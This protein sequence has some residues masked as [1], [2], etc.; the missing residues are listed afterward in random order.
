MSSFGQHR[1]ARV[2]Q[3]CVRAAERVQDVGQG[4]EGEAKPSRSP[5]L[6]VVLASAVRGATSSFK[7]LDVDGKR[8]S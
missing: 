8:N 5:R 3:Q 2:T 6:K 7:V 1:G 4:E